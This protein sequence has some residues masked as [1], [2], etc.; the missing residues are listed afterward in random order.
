M[1][2][3]FKMKV[4]KN[5]GSNSVYHIGKV[6]TIIAV[7]DGK[8]PDPN[9]ESFPWTNEG[10][11][12]KNFEQVSSYFSEEDRFE[13]IFELLEDDFVET[14]EE[15]KELKIEVAIKILK[16]NGYFVRRMPKM[17]E[18]AEE[19]CESGHGDCMFCNMSVCMIG[20]E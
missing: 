10:K 3:N 1:D 5:I 6:G 16:D 19:C 20:N 17:D 9:D 11:L 18:I 8:F 14:I 15:N 7:V 12:F 2:Y 13:T 4:V